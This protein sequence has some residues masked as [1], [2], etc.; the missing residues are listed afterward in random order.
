M[1]KLHGSLLQGRR[2]STAASSAARPP[3]SRAAAGFPRSRPRSCPASSTRADAALCRPARPA[4]P[5]RRSPLGPAPASRARAAVQPCALLAALITPAAPQAPPVL[6]AVR[7]AQDRAAVAV[8]GFAEPQHLYGS[9]LW[10]ACVGWPTWRAARA[11]TGTPLPVRRCAASMGALTAPVPHAQGGA[12]S[13]AQSSSAPAKARARADP[14]PHVPPLGTLP[15]RFGRLP[16]ARSPVSPSA[17]RSGRALPGELLWQPGSS[18]G[19]ARSASGAAL[20]TPRRPASAARSMLSAAHLSMQ[21][22]DQH[23]GMAGC[24]ERGA[25]QH[26]ANMEPDTGS[27][28][29]NHLVCTRRPLL[30][31]CSAINLC[32]MPTRV[33]RL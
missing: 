14:P 4:A 12:L 17:G 25:R 28:P 6:A 26:Q 3:V 29:I 8:Q 19:H 7:G 33:E 10:Q 13:V 21:H 30:P 15:G 18:L 1:L 32:C 11:T 22:T 20:L 27:H 24:C 2:P 5:H 23:S 31:T 9:G 16:F